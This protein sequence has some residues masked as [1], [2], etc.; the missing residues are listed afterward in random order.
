M[1]DVI[2]VGNA[3]DKEL[4]SDMLITLN[5]GGCLHTLI[6]KWK[7]SIDDSELYYRCIQC[8]KYLNCDN[9]PHENLQ[10]VARDRRE[11]Q[12]ENRLNISIEESRVASGITPHLSETERKSKLGK[13]SQKRGVSISWLVEFTNENN[14]W[15]MTTQEVC[16]KFIWPATAASRCR[17]VEL[18]RLERAIGPAK[19]FV[20]HCRLGKWGDLVAALCDGNANRDRFVWIDIFACRQWPC[21]YPDL[22][23]DATIEH[24]SSLVVVCSSINGINE[25]NGR[26]VLFGESKTISQDNKKMIAF[27]RVW[28]LVEMYTASKKGE[29]SYYF[30]GRVI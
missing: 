7:I 29:L 15:H 1:T 18:K 17:Y 21:N 26:D 5:R 30:E 28:C 27:F 13:Q 11:K 8:N 19:T 6:E 2:N 14:C 3:D 24:C 16:N 20:S 12:I 25:V 9:R 23:F 22:D 4:L 10:N